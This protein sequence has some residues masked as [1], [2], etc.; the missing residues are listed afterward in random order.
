[1]LNEY[2]AKIKGGLR[3]CGA[4][5]MCLILQSLLYKIERKHQEIKKC[6]FTT[7]NTTRSI[8]DKLI[9]IDRVY[10]CY[11]I[12]NK[13]LNLILGEEE[14]KTIN[15]WRMVMIGVPWLLQPKIEI[16]GDLVSGISLHHLLR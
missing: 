9:Y 16:T 7:C 11:R 1:M 13:K 5:V 2:V 12:S 8:K 6:I 15:L 10:T 14:S 4:N 3:R